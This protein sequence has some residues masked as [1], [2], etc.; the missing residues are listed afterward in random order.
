MKKTERLS[1]KEFDRLDI[2]WDQL[3]EGV[4]AHRYIAYDQWPNLI[5]AHLWRQ[6]KQFSGAAAYSK[7]LQL[8]GMSGGMA[9]CTREVAHRNALVPSF[10]GTRRAM[11]EAIADSMSDLSVAEEFDDGFAS[12]EG[13]EFDGP[14]SDGAGMHLIRRERVEVD[15]QQIADE[16][17]A[18][19]VE[20]T[21][22][23]EPPH[24]ARVTSTVDFVL[25]NPVN[26]L[27]LMLFSRHPRLAKWPT[28]TTSYC[29]QPRRGTPYRKNT[30]FVSSL[31]PA[32]ALP[33]ICTPTSPC[34]HIAKSRRHPKR[35]ADNSTSAYMPGYYARSAIPTPIIVSYLQAVAERRLRCGNATKLL[36]IDLCAGERSVWKGL[37]AFRRST[38]WRNLRERKAPCPL[39]TRYVAVD[40][41]QLCSADLEIDLANVAVEVVVQKALAYVRWEAIDPGD[42]ALF[43]WFSPPCET[44]SSM[45][46]GTL[47]ASR[48]GGPQRLGADSQY[49]AVR[50]KRGNVAR[51][52]DKMVVSVMRFLTKSSAPWRT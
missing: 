40:N 41:S 33:S 7:S 23:Q 25:E 50:T 20:A 47:S 27:W 11:E 37:Q 9:A 16:A 4:C 2:P 24:A 29:K 30:R 14:E 15:V 42:I 44:Y 45:A 17:W 35:I 1:T 46:L 39:E 10:F 5:K 6:L 22:C 26:A 21:R 19:A 49:R 31:E 48:W 38:Y 28:S 13:L 36:I 18:S 34:Q 51:T 3:T 12:D 43:C 8:R 32:A 52:T